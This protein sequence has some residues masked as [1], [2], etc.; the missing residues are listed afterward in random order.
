MKEYQKEFSK[1]V[2]QRKYYSLK[3]PTLTGPNCPSYLGSYMATNLSKCLLDQ[4]KSIHNFSFVEVM[5]MR[6]RIA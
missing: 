2:Y 5:L 3:Q 6:M 1:A 4:K